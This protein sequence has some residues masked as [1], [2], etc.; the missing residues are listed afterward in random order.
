MISF[1]IPLEALGVTSADEIQLKACDNVFANT[2]TED[3]DGV[4]VFEFG[5]VMAFYT[6]GDCAP[7]GRLNYAYRMAY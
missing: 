2:A 1:R 7:M 3:N 5:D 4:G 6:G